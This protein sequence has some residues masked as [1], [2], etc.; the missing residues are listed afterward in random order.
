MKG[1][2]KKTGRKKILAIPDCGHFTGYKPCFPGTTCLKDCIDPRPIGTNILLVNLE[3]MGHILVTTS[4]LPALKRKY[5][6]STIS[7][8]TLKNADPLLENNPL[9]DR[10]YLWE[11]ESW[12]ML[13]AMEFDVVINIDKSVHAGSFVGGLRAKKKLGYGIDKHGVIV[14]LNKEAEYNYRLGLDDH[15]KFWV[16]TK[17]NTQ[18]LCEAVGLAYHRDEYI[19][20][21]TQEEIDFCRDYRGEVGL[22]NNDLIVGFNTGCSLL[23]QN[24]KMTV[25]Q[26]VVLIQELSGQEGIRLALLGGPEDTER[27]AEIK[28]QVGDQVVNTPTTEG[29]RRGICYENLCDVVISGDSFGMHVAIGLK[30]YVVV[31]FGVSCPQEID[32]FGRGVKLIPEDLV[33]S[34]CWKK[35]CPHNLECIQL[36]DLEQ[37]VREVRLYRDRVERR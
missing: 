18:L 35:T 4:L 2:R 22:D 33:C 23:Y 10:V 25:D 9:V 16:N 5:P 12:L 20:N 15:L 17:P 27:N 13:Q 32:L 28:R 36:I 11:P 34:P 31:W 37:I 6:E 14:P 7:W 1:K 21:L 26:H 3:A 29:L 30:K 24:K 8:I 19:L